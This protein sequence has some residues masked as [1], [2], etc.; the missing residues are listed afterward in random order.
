MSN[1]D[2]YSILSSKPHN[3]HYLNR[4]FNFIQQCCQANSLKTKEELGYT[5]KHHICPKSIFP[6]HKKFRSNKW[7][8]A[9][10]TAR[11]HFIAHWM[12]VG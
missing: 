4:Y 3:K 1:V 2:I 5:E 9:V 11:Q 10:L 12:L 7:N 8:K 6:E